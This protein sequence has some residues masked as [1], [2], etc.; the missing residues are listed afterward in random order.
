MVCCQIKR[1]KKELVE[2][3]DSLWCDINDELLLIKTKKDKKKAIVCG[4][5]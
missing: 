5:I 1:G 2:F 4:V 3:S